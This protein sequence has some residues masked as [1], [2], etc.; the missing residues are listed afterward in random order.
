MVTNG[1]PPTAVAGVESYTY[2]LARQLVNQH[3]VQIVC[4]EAGSAQ[5]EYAVSREMFD[6]LPVTRIVNNLL[7]VTDYELLYRNRRIEQIFAGELDRFQPDLVHVQHC[8]GLSAGC[9]EQALERRLPVVITLHDY[10]FLC[11]AANLLRPDLA[12]CPGTQ[13][14]PNCF[15][16]IPLIPAP[17]ASLALR[18][19][20]GR[21]R[22]LLPRRLRLMILIGLNRL[23]A[24]RQGRNSQPVQQRTRYMR[25]LLARSTALVSPSEY[26]RQ[27]HIEFGVSPRSIR[28]IAHGLDLTPWRNYQRTPRPPN[29][30]LRF[31]Y[32]GV[33]VR[34]K[35][36]DLIVRAFRQLPHA[37]ISLRLYG[38][39]VEGDP[40]VDELSAL[41]AGDE[42]IQFMGPYQNQQIAAILN[43]LDVVLIPSMA[44][45]TF[46]IVARE[47]TLGQ[48][49]VLASRVGALPEAIDDGRTGYLLPPGDLAAWRMRMEELAGDPGQVEQMQRAQAAKQVKSIQAHAQ[50]IMALYLEAVSGRK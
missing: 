48:A 39:K 5:A 6:G 49:A 14:G 9:I 28:V 47:A 30:G 20:Y 44:P 46:S 50:E 1:F 41:A 11:P 34:H 2:A 25:E 35:A 7:D 21:W 38:F 19:G 24:V 12:S 27:R 22:E 26:V 4:R 8:I 40:Y 3:T 29:A 37:N 31:G 17:L 13:V 36:V 32:V 33:L 18:P 16:C 45:E 42:R 10:W 23:R 43:E 15:E